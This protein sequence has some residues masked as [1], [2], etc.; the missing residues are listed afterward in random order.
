MPWNKHD[1]PVSMKNLEPRVRHKAI[2]IA[3]A[4]LDDG[5]EEGRSIA[6][7]TA[8]AEEWDENHPTSDSSHSDKSSDQRSSSGRNHSEP[9]SSSKSHD[10]IHVVPT[11]SG[12]A[13]KEEGKSGHVSTFDTKAEAVDAAKEISS[14][15]NIR[16][17]IHNQDGQIAS[18]IKS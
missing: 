16:A 18:S 1:Y 3:N 2:E 6:I 9:V 8:K 10:N 5:Y 17:I 12:W 11:D 7:A 15:R 13:I 14:K 4:L